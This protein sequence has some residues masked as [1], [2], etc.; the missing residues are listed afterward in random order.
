M[1]QTTGQQRFL[2]ASGLEVSA[3][4]VGTNKWGA[5]RA[6]DDTQIFQAFQAALDGGL[7]LFDTAE[8]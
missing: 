8:V 3:L 7:T 1:T 2:G 5:R 6:K 4:G